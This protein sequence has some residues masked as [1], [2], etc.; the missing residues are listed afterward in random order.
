MPRPREF[1]P[2]AALETAIEVFWAYGYEAASLAELVASMRIGRQSIYNFFGD[3]YSLFLAALDRYTEQDLAHLQPLSGRGAGLDTILE[4]FDD[5]VRRLT[6]SR[7]RQ[8]CLLVNTITE[9]AAVDEAVAERAQR[10]TAQMTTAFAAAVRRAV[11]AGEIEP[12]FS[13]RQLAHHLTNCALGL[14]VSAKAGSSRQSLRQAVE[15]ATAVLH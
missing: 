4:Y 8:G 3:K 13:P 11:K 9:L 1:D 14:A 5:R 10:Y 7:E 6:V 15:A 2:E 12:A